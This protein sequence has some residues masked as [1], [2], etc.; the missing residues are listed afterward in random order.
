MAKKPTYTELEK[1]V[2]DLRK[3]ATQGKRAEEALKEGSE[4]IKLF[5]YSVSHDLKSP[6]IGLYGLTK[7]LYNAYAGIL[8]E[9]GQKYCEHILKTA[10]QIAALVEQIN[11]FISTKEGPLTIERLELKEVL[12]VIKEEF[13]TQLSIRE[14]RWLEPDDIPEIKADR[15][16]IIRAL[17]NLV[18][19]ALK[20]GGEALSEIKIGYKESGKSHILSIKDNGI[21]LKEQNPHQD[22][23]APF[24]R[25]KTSKGIEGSGLGLNIVKEIAEKH[26]GQVWLEPGEERGI[27]FYVSI[28]KNLQ[29]SP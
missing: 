21:G 20:Y 19:N 12:Q 2:T 15:L 9:K 4:K 10:E 27:T 26:G 24:I 22:I 17:R 3:E 25:R 16:C 18:D 28:P 7:R 14:I 5:A 29:L 11:V 1:T 8:D 13:S 6:A 23:F